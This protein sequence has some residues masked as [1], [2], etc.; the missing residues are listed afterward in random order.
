MAITKYF[1]KILFSLVL[2]VI[3]LNCKSADKAII[4]K[5]SAKVPVAGTLTVSTDGVFMRDGKVYQGIGVNYFNAFY[6]TINNNNDKSYNEGF[7]YLS[8]NK[9]PFIRF[10]TNGFWPNELKLYVE[11]KKLYFKLLDEFVKSAET[12][13]IG[14]IPSLFWFY[15]TVPDL[16]GEHINQWGNPNSKTIAFMR[17]YTAEVVSRYKDSP[18]IWGWEFGNEVN[19]YCD[20][21]EQSINYLPKVNEK[22]GSPA[23]RTIEDALT[24]NILQIAMNEFAAKV[25]QIDNNRPIF[26]GNSTP[27]PNM[28]HRY[29]YGN[30]TKDSSS[31]FT[32]LLDAQNPKSLGTLT[33]HIYP[34]NENAYFSDFNPKA[35]LSQIIQESMLSSKELKRPFFLG[36]F[37]SPKTVDSTKEAAK[38]KELLTAIIENKVQLSALWV[39]DYSPHDAT[40]NTTPTNSRKYQLEAIIEANSKF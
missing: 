17:T 27:A 32:S 3:G 13:G 11:N 23:K 8:N 19:A 37:G 25:R 10:T 2:L 7:K 29:K 4:Q 24:T 1:Y 15:P 33:L 18:A 16:V 5:K 20:L 9:I 30:W 6:R 35:T 31:D 34:E 28:F 38:F 12:Y 22:L 39:F 26:S 14:L 21:L 36:E 40:W